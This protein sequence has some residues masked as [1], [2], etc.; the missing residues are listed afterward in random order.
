MPGEVVC[1]FP[2]AEQQ[3]AGGWWDRTKPLQEG[4]CRTKRQNGL[5]DV[6]VWPAAALP[7][8]VLWD[9]WRWWYLQVNSMNFEYKY[10][11]IQMFTWKDGAYDCYTKRGEVVQSFSVVWFWGEHSCFQAAVCCFTRPGVKELHD[12][13]H[14]TACSVHDGSCA[15]D[16]VVT[17]ELH[18][19]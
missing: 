19:T 2:W 16:H 11:L 17:N 8:A 13:G 6:A 15:G 10:F 1:E 9:C 12:S 4:I 18:T 7:L 5:V 3:R 14:H